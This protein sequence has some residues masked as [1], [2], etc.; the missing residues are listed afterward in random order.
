M[1][2]RLI[3]LNQFF[4][5]LTLLPFIREAGF[6]ADYW[7]RG[8]ETLRGYVPITHNIAITGERSKVDDFISKNKWTTNE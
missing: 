3:T 6:G 5:I 2:T 1:I 7:P 8:G 4:L